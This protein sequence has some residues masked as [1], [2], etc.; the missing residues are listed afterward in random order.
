MNMKNK[1]GRGI[2]SPVPQG[3]SEDGLGRKPGDRGADG[4]VGPQRLGPNSNSGF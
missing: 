2:V 4:H 3:G 1:N